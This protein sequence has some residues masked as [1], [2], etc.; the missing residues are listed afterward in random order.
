M[1]LQNVCITNCTNYLT[2]RMQSSQRYFII[3]PLRTLRSPR[4]NT[5][6]AICYTQLQNPHYFYL[7]KND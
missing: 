2:Q 4:E 7:Q 6:C 3:S 5:Y 1:I